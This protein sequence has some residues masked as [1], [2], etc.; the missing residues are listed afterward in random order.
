M[1]TETMTPRERW[2]AVLRH[3]L[4]DR[5]PMDYWSTP[6][7]DRKLLRHL[8]YTEVRP[9][10]QAL[11]VDFPVTVVPRYVGPRLESGLDVYGIR[12]TDVNYGDGSYAEPTAPPLAS[13]QSV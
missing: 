9:M 5:T 7:F 10:L 12:Y 1:P 2:L 4:P 8:G 3:E 6:E 11:H 13:Y